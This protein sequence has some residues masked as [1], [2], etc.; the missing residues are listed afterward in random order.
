[1]IFTDIGTGVLQLKNGDFDC[2]AVAAGNGDAIIASNPEIAM[3]G[4]K[5]FVDEKYTGN[6]ILLQKGNDAMTEAVNNILSKAE[7]YYDK[8]YEDAKSTAGIDV[9]YDDEGN[10]IT[11]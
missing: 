6:V 1:M 9:S 7:Q 3:S 10:A 11:E 8:W 5:F 4:F 2:I